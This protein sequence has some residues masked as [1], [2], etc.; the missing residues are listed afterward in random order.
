MKPTSHR[1]FT[2]RAKQ[3][4]VALLI[5]VTIVLLGVTTL[6]VNQLS[7]NQTL[8]KRNLTTIESINVAKQ[9]L[10]GFALEQNTPGTLP[11]PD[12][13]GDGFENPQGAN[14][15]SQLGL[16]PHR[17]LNIARQTDGAGADLW[18]AVDLNYTDNTGTLKNSSLAT[19]LTLDG[20]TVAAIVIGP[21]K[22]LHGQTR[23]ALTRVDYLEGI[24]ADANLGDYE[25]VQ[26]DIQND[27]T[28]AIDRSGFWSLIEQRALATTSGLLNDYRD[29]C[30][31]YPW[32]A[33]FGGPYDS[34]TSQQIGAPPFNSALPNDW[35][36]ACL[37]GTAPVP[38]AWLTTNWST[39]LLYRMC[40]SGEGNCITVNDSA[41]SPAAGVVIAPGITLAGQTRPD[42]DFGDYFEDENS[43]LPDNLFR[44]TRVL[45]HNS[46]YNDRTQTLNP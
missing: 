40:Q 44:Q 41:T 27:I 30:G 31:E 46:T 6:L 22:A 15:E 24:N 43:S 37:P 28:S 32:A 3:D 2:S 19:S 1:S 8:H 12:T 23:G 20:Q 35:G 9:A 17:T 10:L 38:P 26:S 29:Q 18:Y 33:D 14:C 25:S 36:V 21:G 5:F 45:D 4:G 34:V 16:L 42:N 7:V 13:T 39:E 11:C